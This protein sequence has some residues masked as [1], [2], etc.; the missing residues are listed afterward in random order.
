MR[1]KATWSVRVAVARANVV[2]RGNAGV[3][4][5]DT[6]GWYTHPRTVYLPIE[7]TNR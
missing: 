4:Y 1:R 3:A 6:F 2:K 7:E 5:V